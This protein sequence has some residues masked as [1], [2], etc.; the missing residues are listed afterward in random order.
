[1]KHIK[2]K[3][4]KQRG[5][6]L[7]ELMIV[8]GIISIAFLGIL[9]Y[10][11]RVSEQMNAESAGE[12]FQT[13]GQ[14]LSTYI[15]KE[16]SNLSGCIAPGTS[17]LIPWATIT[18]NAGTT[19]AAGCVLNNRQVLSPN[20]NTKNLFKTGYTIQIQNSAGGSL[21]GL[22]ISD[23]AIL[24]P[25]SNGA[26]TPRYDWIGLAMK[27][28]GAQSGMTFA[29]SPGVMKGLGAG[30]SLS[31]A[32]YGSITQ[33]GLFGYRVNYQGS[34]DDIYLRL[35]GAYPM[36]GNLNMGNYNINNITD[37]NFNGW[38]N[39]NN[40][41]LNNL[42]TGYISNS[43]N[44]Q[45]NTLTVTNSIS[46]GGRETSPMPSGWNAEYIHTWDIYAEGIVGT[47][48]GGTVQAYMDNTGLIKANNIQLTTVTCAGAGATSG[49]TAAQIANVRG[50]DCSNTAYNG[51]LTDR[52]PQYV[53]KG[54][55]V[56]S[57][58]DIVNKPACIATGNGTNA[59]R[60]VIVP[61]IQNVYG[62]YD[63]QVD[64]IVNA[65]G[66]YEVNTSRTPYTAE[67][68]QIYATDNGASWTVHLTSAMA[69]AYGATS[70]FKGLAQTYCDFGG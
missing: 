48:T 70:G 10:G 56:V 23:A 19:N 26:G 62:D 30:W 15:N 52:L 54:N 35:N 67:Q 61:Q 57:N 8:L 28:V 29:G 65:D 21:G 11:T 38:L 66:T 24:D 31:T 14:S 34:N 13:I 4:I 5:F 3:N 44:I 33:V 25:K 43:G 51:L 12:Q 37:V 6:T 20:T 2:I 69:Q 64:M 40:A 45:S 53:S 49:L 46:T 32:E 9:S 17:I 58:G 22:V 42:K 36:I 41:L 55:I 7:I 60:I 18:T 27:K 47:G 50:K 63:V 16:S 68:I 59:A 1:M 39:G